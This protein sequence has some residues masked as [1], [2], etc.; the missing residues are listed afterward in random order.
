MFEGGIAQEAIRV[1]IF[2]S[3]VFNFTSLV[4]FYERPE[5]SSRKIGYAAAALLIAI[6]QLDVLDCAL[7]GVAFSVPEL[8][9]QI[10]LSIVVFSSLGSVK[11]IATMLKNHGF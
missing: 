3:A 10:G 6:G 5:N 4:F 9:T 1:V 7:R 8:A 2:L 11:K